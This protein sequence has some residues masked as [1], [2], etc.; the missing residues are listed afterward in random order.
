M[1]NTDVFYIFQIFKEVSAQH[2]ELFEF[3]PKMSHTAL[4]IHPHFPHYY[5]GSNSV[6]IS[7]N[8]NF[9]LQYSSILFGPFEYTLRQ[10]SP[11]K[12]ICDKF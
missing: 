9:R 10:S 11:L 6:H 7:L 5:N 1:K 8:L 3:S 2:L 12:Q 4:D